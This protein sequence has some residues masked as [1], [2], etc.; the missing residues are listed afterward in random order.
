MVEFI[1]NEETGRWMGERLQF[2]EIHSG[3]WRIENKDPELLGW[4]EKMRVGRFMHYCLLLD[5]GCYLSAGC[6]DE[7]RAFMKKIYS[8]DKQRETKEGGNE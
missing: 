2:F 3:N 5:N 8:I 6:L 1:Y 7:A 4:F